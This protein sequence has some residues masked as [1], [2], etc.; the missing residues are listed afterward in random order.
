MLHN[1]VLIFHTLIFTYV[2]F[3]LGDAVVRRLAVE[4]RSRVQRAVYPILLGYGGFGFYGLLL[5]LIGALAAFYLHLLILIILIL[6]AGKIASHVLL[7]QRS[8]PSFRALAA[9]IG[10]GFGD[11]PFL[12]ALLCVWLV[13]NFLIVFVPITGYDSIRY[14]VPIILDMIQNQGPSFSA[15]LHDY[16]PWVPLFGEIIYAVPLIAF[17]NFSAP[18]IFQLLQYGALLLIILLVYDAAAP[19]IADPRLRLVL[20]FLI[21]SIFD[22]ARETM[23]GGY[24]DILLVL[25]GLASAIP[26][27]EWVSGGANP[28]RS[29]MLRLSALLLGA[30]L[31]IK[32]NAIYFVLINT[33][34]LLAGLLFRSS[35][36]RR[37]FSIL[38]L[39]LGSAV[40]VSGFWYVKN[41]VWFGN[42]IH[43]MRF[44]DGSGVIPDT[45]IY[46][47]SISN[48]ISFPLYH[49]GSVSAHDSSSK[50]IVFGYFV[51]VYLLVIFFAG[52]RRRELGGMNGLMLA[53]IHLYLWLIFFTAHYTRYFLAPLILVPPLLLS[54]LDAGYRWLVG[55]RGGKISYLLTKISTWVIYAAV[56]V[57]FLGN[58]HYFHVKFLYA[59]NFL[60]TPEYIKEIGSQ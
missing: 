12:K 31:G 40:A 19:R 10:R 14:H 18:F 36:A 27:M 32:Y 13:L 25:F 48:L 15:S 24:T 22:L 2:S 35:A 11:Y 59:F 60:S 43:P 3:L 20:P 33:L 53:F 26:V 4:F 30:A 8:V 50:L 46:E 38:S 6:S 58:I 57:L 45:I 39:Y 54:L 49:F 55:V 9:L 47:R 41:A 34:F 23:H 51:L 5:G 17:A 42:P 1:L 21:L 37:I 16:Y 28:Q 29:G 52:F 44:W 7:L 56:I